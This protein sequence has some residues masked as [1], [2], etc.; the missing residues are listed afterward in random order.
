MSENSK[1]L[2]KAQKIRAQ[3]L[4]NQKTI[5]KNPKLE[6]KLAAFANLIKSNKDESHWMN[7]KLTFHIDSTNAFSLSEVN[8]QVKDENPI[9]DK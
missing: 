6:E 5:Q 3:F 8:Y 7:N 4:L 2:T 1:S 9:K